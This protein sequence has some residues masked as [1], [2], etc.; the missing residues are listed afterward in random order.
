MKSLLFIT[1]IM[2]VAPGLFAC[3]RTTEPKVD[4]KEFITDPNCKKG[5]CESIE[6]SLVNGSDESLDSAVAQG[7][8]GQ[9]IEW[10]VKIKTD[11]NAKRVKIAILE[12]PQWLQQ[13]SS[14][15]TSAISLRGT[16]TEFVSKSRVIILA[17]DIAQCVALE[18]VA[19]DCLSPEKSFEKYDRKINFMFSIA[20]GS[21]N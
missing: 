6:F 11:Q 4:V 3:G 12:S 15:G 7:V 14:S 20:G 10:T 19:K 21:S 5:K 17:R 8:V 2:L 16:P 1:S 13:K 18:S 9:P